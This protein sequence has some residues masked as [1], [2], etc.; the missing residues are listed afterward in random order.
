M[1]K[2]SFEATR[3]ELLAKAIAMPLNEKSIAEI[4]DELDTNPR[5][6]LDPDPTGELGMTTTEKNF[7]KWYLQHRNIAVAA[8]LAEISVEDGMAIYRSF[9]CQAELQ[10]IDMAWKLRQLNNST[11]TLDQIGSVLTGYVFDQMPEAERLSTKDKMSA[12]KMIMDIHALKQKV[13]E[14]AQPVDVVDVESQIKDMSVDALKALIEKT[15][16]S[17]TENDEKEAL[18]NVID[19]TSVLSNDDL[20]YLRS[21]SVS[22]LKSLI[23]EQQRTTQTEDDEAPKKQVTLTPVTDEDAVTGDDVTGA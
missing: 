21:L 7:T 19:D 6:S 22:Q 17:D 12:M 3:N 18:I 8:Q 2:K 13:I 14:D 23:E 11:L 1:G 15:K 20:R 9:A 4:A 16:A 10:R 5:Y